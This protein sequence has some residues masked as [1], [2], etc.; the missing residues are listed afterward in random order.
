MKT[1]VIGIKLE[2]LILN[3]SRKNNEPPATTIR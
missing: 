1:K 3:I 2:M